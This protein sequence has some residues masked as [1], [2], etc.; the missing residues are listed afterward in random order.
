V[1]PRYKQKA[2]IKKGLC[3]MI[4][5]CDDGGGWWVKLRHESMKT[6]EDGE[7]FRGTYHMEFIE[8]CDLLV[9]ASWDYN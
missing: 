1:V 7:C 2:Q 9:Q 8:R 6:I 5:N 4:M 3:M